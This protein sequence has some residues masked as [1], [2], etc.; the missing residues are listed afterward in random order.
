M[1]D[2]DLKKYLGTWFEIARIKNK[3]EPEMTNVKAE[4]SLNRDGSIKVTNTGYVDGKLRSISGVAEET[5][6]PGVL[7]LSFFPEQES[8]YKIL[9]VSDDYSYALVGGDKKDNLWF[10]SR[11]PELIEEDVMMRLVSIGLFA[12]YRC[13]NIIF[14]KQ[15]RMD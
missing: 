9:F 1:Y 13:E 6:E 14:T 11:T 8:S 5:D 2:I 4:Y 7:R 3:F 15:N 10:L 12:G